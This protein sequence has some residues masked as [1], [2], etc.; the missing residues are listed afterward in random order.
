MENAAISSTEFVASCAHCGQHDVRLLFCDRCK[1]AQYCSRACQLASWRTHRLACIRDPSPSPTEL[2]ERR[3]TAA[4]LAAWFRQSDFLADTVSAMAYHCA[5]RGCVAR[6]EVP[7]ARDARTGDLTVRVSTHP[8]LNN[9]SAHAVI[10]EFLRT[11]SHMPMLVE[12]PGGEVNK[13]ALFDTSK[14]AA[15]PGDRLIIYS[16]TWL[17]FCER[18]LKQQADADLSALRYVAVTLHTDRRTPTFE[19]A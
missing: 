10:N 13:I 3:S 19:W 16:R 11:G 18:I 5:L 12:R 9:G 6:V 17:R 1:I 15:R 2:A 7:A 8:T 14:V 4:D